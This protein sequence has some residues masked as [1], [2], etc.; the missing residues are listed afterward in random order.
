MLLVGGS[1]DS[2]ISYSGGVILSVKEQ[3]SNLRVLLDLGLPLDKQ[4]AVVAGVPFT[5][6][7][8]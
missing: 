5:N 4:V 3:V 2:G 7:G 1:S 8:W 6:F